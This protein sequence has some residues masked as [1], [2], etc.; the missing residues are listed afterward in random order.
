VH[1]DAPLEVP[2]WYLDPSID[3]EAKGG[4]TKQKYHLLV[5]SILTVILID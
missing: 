2:D 5:I 4:A 1:A 3:T